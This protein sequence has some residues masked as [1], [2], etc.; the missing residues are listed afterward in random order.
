MCEFKW[1][2]IILMVPFGI[3]MAFAHL[4]MICAPLYFVYKLIIG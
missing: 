2:Q 4:W 3:A 1:W